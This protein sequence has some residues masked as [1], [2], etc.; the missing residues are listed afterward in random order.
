MNEQS[1][2]EWAT[3]AG[4]A[5]SVRNGG[6]HWIFE[7]PGFLAEYW[8]S[9]RRLVINKRWKKAAFP[10]DAAELRRLIEKRLPR[11]ARREPAYASRLRELGAE[12]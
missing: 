12:V 7:R 4:L 6:E 11:P 1:I 5:L 8:P 9:T 3:G 10:A 2:R